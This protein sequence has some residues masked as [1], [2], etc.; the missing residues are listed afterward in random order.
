MA[1]QS[2][3]EPEH[4]VNSVRARRD[5]AETEDA[6]DGVGTGEMP[7]DIH[8]RHLLSHPGTVGTADLGDREAE[9]VPETWRTPLAF[10]TAGQ[11]VNATIAG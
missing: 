2:T 4:S 11:G 5:R 9:A 1:L 6:V 3:Q 7:K 10:A 8:S